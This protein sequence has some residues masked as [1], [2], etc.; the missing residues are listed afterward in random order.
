VSANLYI[1]GEA[2]AVACAC[3]ED[4]PVVTVRTF[5]ACVSLRLT[6]AQLMALHRATVEAMAMLAVEVAA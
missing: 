3:R 4:E 2:R 6:P 1:N 5:E